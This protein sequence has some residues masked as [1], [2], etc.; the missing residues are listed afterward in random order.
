MCRRNILTLPIPTRSNDFP[1]VQYADD[2]LIVLPAFD[3]QLIALKDMLQKFAESTGL[4]VNFSK[5]SLIPMN[6]SEE[7]G[8][9][10]AALLGCLI[11]SM[12]F[13][14]LGLPMGTS[15]PTIYDLMP[16]VD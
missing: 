8:A 15:R 9:R 6:L 12:P 1:I 16:L 11:G 5:S 2:T 14:Y 3:S 7:E 13:T 10:I 4:H